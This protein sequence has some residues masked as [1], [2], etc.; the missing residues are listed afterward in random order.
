MLPPRPE[1]R[2][3]RAGDMVKMDKKI[4]LTKQQIPDLNRLFPSKRTKKPA[5]ELL[6]AQPN[7]S[8]YGRGDRPKTS[9]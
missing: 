9:R 8:W 2:G 5:P 4:V 7:G 6:D 3:F 1:G